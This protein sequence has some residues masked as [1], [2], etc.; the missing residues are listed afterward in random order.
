MDF[1]IRAALM[2]AGLLASAT[3]SRTSLV[4]TPWAHSS[5]I[6]S[7]LLLDPFDAPSGVEVVSRRPAWRVRADDGQILWAFLEF[8]EGRPIVTGY[9]QSEVR[10]IRRETQGAG[11]F[12]GLTTGAVIGGAFGGPTGALIGGL[13]GAFLLGNNNGSGSK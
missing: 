9:A 6:G 1:F 8:H 7:M 3:L 4:R 2:V 11:A 5:T 10:S 13:V 12:A